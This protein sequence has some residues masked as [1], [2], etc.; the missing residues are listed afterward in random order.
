MGDVAPERHVRICPTHRVEVEE[1][2]SQLYCPKGWHA[3]AKF[4]VLDR[5]KHT[6]TDVPVDGSERHGGITEVKMEPVTRTAAAVAVAQAPATASKSGKDVLEKVKFKDFAG[7]VLWIRLVRVRSPRRP[8]VFMVRWERHDDG[9]HN[10]SQQAALCAEPYLERARTAYTKAVA[11]ARADGW[12]ESAVTYR[13][14]KFL[15]L[16]KAAKSVV[17]KG[18]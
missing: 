10:V 1:R 17:K 16:P 15:P 13:E 6:V 7:T 14:L 18:R 8:D 2:G 4:K 9:S 5:L 3:V 11:D 12:I